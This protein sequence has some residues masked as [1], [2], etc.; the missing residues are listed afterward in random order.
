LE[1][2]FSCLSAYGA[3]KH[4]HN[5]WLCREHLGDGALY[6]RWADLF[7]FLVAGDGREIVARPLARGSREAFH[8][9][10][11]GQALSFALIKQG[12]EPL[13]ATTVAVD[14]KA[15]ALLGDNGYGKSTLAAAFLQAGHRLVT[16]DLLNLTEN[17]GGFRAHPGP[18]RI[19]LF[20]EIAERYLAP[21]DAGTPMLPLSRKLVFPLTHAHVSRVSV[22]L[23]ALYLLAPPNGVHAKPVNIRTLS[24]RRAFLKIVRSTFN[25]V[26]VGAHRME[27]Q[28]ALAT[29]LAET[30][31]VKVISYS[32]VLDRLPAVRDAILADLEP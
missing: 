5:E 9:F 14:G 29:R 23:K 17:G 19:K 26:I 3:A 16:D 25:T 11:L 22:P 15:V 30:V 18:P 4:V 28:F 2:H 12:F 32:R 6:L 27:R 24:R 10:L 31:P 8:T 20:S 21:S 1:S 13:H 7:E